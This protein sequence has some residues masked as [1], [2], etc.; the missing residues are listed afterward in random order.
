M[1]GKVRQEV[2]IG[3][4]GRRRVGKGKG[5]LIKGNVLRD[6]D[7]IVRKVKTTISFMK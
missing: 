2:K 7:T 5:R 3:G 1:S 4:L 6:D